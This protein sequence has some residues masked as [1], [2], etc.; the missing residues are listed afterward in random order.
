MAYI[1]AIC[2]MEE[3][4]KIENGEVGKGIR[5]L[6][7]HVK[8]FK[9]DLWILSALGLVSAVANGFVPYITGRFFDAL[10]LLSKGES[11]AGVWSLPLWGALLTAWAITQIIANNIDWVMDR[12]RR[13]TDSQIHLAIQTYG[14]VHL[15]RLPLSFHKSAHI[16]GVLQKISNLGWRASAIMRTVI[17]FVPEFLSILIG[18]TLAASIN[19]FLASV[20]IVGVLLYLLLLARVLR[21][22]AAADFVAHHTW[23]EEWNDAA[24]VVH[25]IE[26]VKQAGAEEY[27]ERN[28]REGFLEKTFA[29]WYRLERTWSNV[30]FYQRTIV[31]FTQL[32]VFIFSVKLVGSGVI[33]VGEL[34]ALNGYA[35]MFFGPFVSLG[36][37]W[38]IIQNGITS[39]AH[40]E[41]IFKE[42]EEVYAPK[43]AIALA[44]ISGKVEFKHASFHY[45]E[46]QP[47]VLSRINFLVNPGEIIAF[48]GES[49]VGKSTAISLI[50]GYYFPI[51]GEVL[52][53][54]VDTRK[55]NLTALR[56]HIAVVPQEVALFNDTIK[57]NIKYGTP[58]ATDKDVAHAAHEAHIGEFIATLPDGYNTVVGERGIKL[59]VG[60]KQR[61]SI[62]RAILRN[63][64][65]LILDEPTS[66][67][68]AKTEQ[69]ITKALERLMKE[70]TTFIIAH[71]LSTVR[72]A[73]K[74]FV[75]EKGKIVETGTHDELIAK[76]DGVYHRLY[77]YQ[78]GLH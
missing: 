33:T 23:N 42:P 67:L 55:W 66:A 48:V 25:Q 78:I 57:A 69:I 9:R 17:Q 5:A 50:S 60:Q 70:R 45:G 30:S 49:G 52:I 73:N 34:V 74:I 10:I 26:S 24:E 64:A 29:L 65:I 61:V 16:D 68:D 27:E 56:K 35:L 12:M 32:A 71:R 19:G 3:I 1:H 77:Q 14:F 38:Q 13:K 21:P 36:H 37:S 62:A 43:D 53:D 22:A 4:Q 6:W 15:F 40:A 76:K 11:A 58:D 46:G 41:K 18:I 39:A 75:F 8:P 28:V 20:L 2:G 72:K 59:S 54:G 31:F 51:A 44:E 47:A 63:P 7:R